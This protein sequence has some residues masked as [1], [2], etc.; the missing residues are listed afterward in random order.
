MVCSSDGRMVCRLVG[1]LVCRSVCHNFLKVREVTLMLLSEH[2]FEYV[3]IYEYKMEICYQMF[4]L[5]KVEGV[6]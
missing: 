3:C 1:R 2:L 6:G 5:Q 4:C